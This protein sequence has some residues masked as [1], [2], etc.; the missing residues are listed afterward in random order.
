ML[1]L[2]LAALVTLLG[3]VLR[4]RR[5]RPTDNAS[6]LW[7]LFG[8]ALW[9]WICVGLP[10]RGP[11]HA[12]ELASAGL[13]LLMA[14]AS[15]LLTEPAWAKLRRAVTVGALIFVFSQPL[16][17]ALRAPRLSWPPAAPHRSI[18]ALTV[19]VLLD[20][21]NANAAGPIAEAMRRTGRPVFEKALIPAGDG[22]AKLVPALFTG[23]DF[24]QAKPC[25]WHTICSGGEVLDFGRVQASRPDIDVVGFYMPY[26][27]ISGLR[28]CE[29]LSPVQPYTDLTRWYCAA[30]RRSAWLAD[31]GGIAARRRCAD[32]NGRVW[33]SLAKRVEQAVWRAPAWTNGG[34]L[35]VHAPLPHPPGEGDGTLGDHYRAN[36][37]KAALLIGEMADR[38]AMQKRS[39]ALLVFSDHPLRPSI[40][41]ESTQYRA[42]GCPS[43]RSLLD[44]RVP[45]LISGDLGPMADELRTNRNVFQLIG[46]ASTEGH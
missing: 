37:A 24:G 31:H 12:P 29:E 27:A 21:L 5:P 7:V 18:P 14:L 30:L 39:F 1:A 33:S 28:F 6:R 44:D 13:W 2:G 36:V 40:W 8:A 32:Q 23:H 20:E 16:L 46:A 45:L 22:T 9:I 4:W 17:A 35:Y 43:D 42:E 11:I 3:C 19:V 15:W 34:L 41:C 26:C 10:G 25:G 38:L